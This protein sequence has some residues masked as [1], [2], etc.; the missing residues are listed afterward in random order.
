MK[1]LYTL[2]LCTLFSGALQSQVKGVVYG[3]NKKEKNP[4]YG[5]KI[6]LLSANRGAISD[7]D[8]KFE[9]ILPK[10][11]PDTLVFSAMGFY[12][13]TVV[14]TKKI[15]SFLLKLYFILTSFYQR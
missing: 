3:S 1:Y 5:A 12:P 13:D 4:I 9:L 11:L 2:L 15:D 7:E 14:V 10:E 8:G 6:K